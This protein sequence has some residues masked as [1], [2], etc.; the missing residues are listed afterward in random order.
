MTLWRWAERRVQPKR[1]VPARHEP[2][3]RNLWWP[4][5]ICRKEWNMDYQ[6][7]ESGEYFAAVAESYDRLQ[8]ILS[9]PY[10]K[11]LEIM[12][13]LIPLDPND[14]LWSEGTSH[15]LL[16]PMELLEKLA[17]PV[18]RPG[19]ISCATTGSWPPGPGT[20]AASCPPNRLRSRR[21]RIALR[22]LL[23]APIG[24]GGRPCW[25]G[26]FPPTSAHAR[27]VAPADRRRPDRSGLD[28]DLS[29]GGRATGGA[30]AEGPAA[31]AV[32]VR[33]RTSSAIHQGPY[34]TLDNG[35]SELHST[36]IGALFFLYIGMRWST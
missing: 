36:D 28:P 35:F 31:A 19:F 13:D 23:P 6:P 8:P 17:A 34:R 4:G 12:V 20:A 3:L 5:G 11:G 16:S 29:G 24:C 15:L 2:Q 30:P 10:S 7:T 26:C 18:P 1:A 32:R 25:R 21:R 27:P 22:A 14:A 9:P 33:R